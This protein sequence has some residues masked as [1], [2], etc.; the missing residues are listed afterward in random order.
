MYVCMAS[1]KHRIYTGGGFIR[2]DEEEGVF[3]IDIIQLRK[4]G[5]HA[6]YYMA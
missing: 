3:N 5:V 1:C 6:K 2:R 4:V